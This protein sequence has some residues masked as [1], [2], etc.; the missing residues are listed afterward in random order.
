MITIDDLT[1]I[2]ETKRKQIIECLDDLLTFRDSNGN[3]SPVISG[4]NLYKEISKSDRVVTF[5]S[6]SCVHCTLRI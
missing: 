6:S 4:Y 3:L 2:P 1:G 5:S